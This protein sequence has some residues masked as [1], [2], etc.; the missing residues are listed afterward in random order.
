M[1]ANKGFFLHDFFRRILPGDRNLF[2]PILEFLKWRQLTRNL[3]LL[4]WVALWLAICG[5][6]TFSFVRNVSVLHGF[7]Q[8]FSEPPSLTKNISDNLMLMDKFRSELLE[9][10]DANQNWW[11]PR[12]GL[13]DTLDVEKRLT[14][15]YVNLFETGF[16]KPM[17]RMLRE[18]MAEI[19]AD[20]PENYIMVYAQH[21][22]G[23]IK[24]TQEYIGSGH[25]KKSQDLINALSDILI[26]LDNNVLPGTA[27]KYRGIYLYYLD[28]GIDKK[29]A[30]SNIKKLQTELV[31]L[32]YKKSEHLNWLVK[33]ANNDVKIR[34]ITLNDYWGS[35]NSQKSGDKIIVDGAYTVNGFKEINEFVGYL[36]GAL[37]G[38]INIAEEEK[39]FFKW[40]KKEYF[41]AWKSFAK[42][43]S[44]GQF[45]L[46]DPDD[47]QNMASEMTTP[48]NPYFDLIESMS[49]ELKPFADGKNVPAWVKQLIEV[50]SIIDFAAKEKSSQKEESILTKAVEKSGKLVHE[51][52]K[53]AKALTDKDREE[54]RLYA[55]KA[56]N[57]YLAELEELLPVSTARSQAYK[58][59]SEFFPYSLKPSESKSP[60]FSAFGEVQKF[61]NYLSSGSDFSL[62]MNLISGP[63]RFLLFYVSMETA[64]SLQHDWEDIVL[65]GIQGVASENLPEV[66]FSEKGVVWKFVNGP[67]SPF[68]GRNQHGYFV[69][70][71]RGAH[72]PFENSFFSFV[73][74]G[75]A[76]STSLKPDYNVQISTLPIDVND[77]AKKEPYQTSIELGCVK[78][79]TRLDNF[80]HPASKMFTWSPGDCGGVTLRIYFEGLTLTKK[81]SGHDGFPLFLADFKDGSKTFTPED[82]PQA[83]G[84]LK[85]LNVTEIK[86]S[87]EITDS[88]PVI[89]LVKKV[90]RQTPTVIA[91]CWSR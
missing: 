14:K 7:T 61:E 47:W 26:L 23:R 28:H 59:A 42:L 49:K 66:L 8:D 53:E 45:N 41:Q 79:K 68:L 89:K 10:H 36:E 20:T 87:Y 55:A 57:A 74:R 12:F 22:V 21:L 39:K 31:Q 11:I 84:I 76:V 4:S 38:Y 9:L 29:T 72:I 50:Q 88:K 34:D 6:L 82:F 80:N 52:V 91:D 1:G 69:K 54:Q 90:P 43:F 18:R 44:K 81:Y 30:Q 83:K 56:F 77:D 27:D 75:A 13:R 71:A 58:A 35:D 63:V 48:H 62:P 25:L 5:L 16:V 46:G 32:I 3:G 40:Y 17:D 19:T 85:E 37:P 78:G 65:G 64:C 70:K 51:V 73:T 33:W 60:F 2:T 86:V 67:A 24:L 15:Q